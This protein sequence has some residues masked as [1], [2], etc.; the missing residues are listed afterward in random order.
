MIWSAVINPVLSPASPQA[1]ALSDLFVV[2][3]IVCAVIFF[4]VV[5]LIAWCMTHFRQ[6]RQPFEPRQVAGNKKL[7]VSWTLASVLVLIFLFVLTVRGMRISDPPTE[8]EPDITVIGH[9]WW[10]E[11]RYANGTVTANEIHIPILSNILIRVDSADV[12][13]SF[14]VPQ[15]G[16]KIDAIPGHPNQLW[17]RADQAGLYSGTCAVFCGLQHAWMRILIV[18]QSPEEYLDWNSRQTPLAKAPGTPAALRGERTFREKTCIQCH[19]IR[20]VNANVEIG[21][22]LTHFA[23]RRTIGTGVLQNNLAGLHRWL[24][25]PQEVKPGC[26]MPDF[27]LTDAD[28]EGLTAYLETLK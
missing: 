8:R 20:G 25:N 26:H 19:S 12:I 6:R 28:V 15:L 21:P 10:W 1:R 2:T 4:I 16:R 18:A 24:T 7:E 27:Q 14:W 5:A 23:S 11:A 22:D 13:H 9:Q 3:L 17:I